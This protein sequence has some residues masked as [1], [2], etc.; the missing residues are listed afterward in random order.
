MQVLADGRVRR[1]S[2]EW[3]KIM[4]RHR[5][6]RLPI[7]AFC[8][9]EE[10]SRSAFASWKRRLSGGG[11]KSPSFVELTRSRT[12]PAVKPAVA[13]I[14]PAGTSFELVLPGGVTLRWRG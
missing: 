14:S 2:S 6:S 10:I 3:E 5:K 9:R 12:S 11:K 8:E 7:A 1:T 4:A 13:L